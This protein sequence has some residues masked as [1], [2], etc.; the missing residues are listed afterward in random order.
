[1]QASLVSTAQANSYEQTLRAA[2]SITRTQLAR[3]SAFVEAWQHLTLIKA[4]Q[5]TSLR[6]EVHTPLWSSYT[7]TLRG[8]VRAVVRWDVN[9]AFWSSYPAMCT[10]YRRSGSTCIFWCQ[11]LV[12]VAAWRISWLP[13]RLFSQITGNM[14]RC[15][16][17]VGGN[18]ISPRHQSGLALCPQHESELKCL[19]QISF[20][21]VK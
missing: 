21:K 11:L 7:W 10:N 6:P 13:A 1:M 3:C 15:T 5:E 8:S 9:L 18:S 19:A 12:R 20:V 14:R 4:L 16:W 2:A 17:R